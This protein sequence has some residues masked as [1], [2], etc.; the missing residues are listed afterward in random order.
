M[1]FNHSSALQDEKNRIIV[2]G[3]GGNCFSFG[4]HF[5]QDFLVIDLL[6]LEAACLNS[7]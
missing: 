5:N 3:G 4:T 6:A 7:E 1:L 2:S